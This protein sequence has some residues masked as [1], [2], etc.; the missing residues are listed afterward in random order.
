MLP[1]FEL[2]HVGTSQR[3][4]KKS[5]EKHEK[6]SLSQSWIFTFMFFSSPKHNAKHSDGLKHQ[7]DTLQGCGEIYDVKLFFGEGI[8]GNLSFPRSCPG[9]GCVQLSHH[10]HFH[11]LSRFSN[12]I[13][14]P[15]RRIDNLVAFKTLFEF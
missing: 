2:C 1:G 14:T 8:K 9:D 15:Q 5:T 7:M 12:I 3:T 10:D 11:L 6:T 4:F 13:R